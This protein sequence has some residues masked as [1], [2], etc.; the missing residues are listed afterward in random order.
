MTLA[1]HLAEDLQGRLKVWIGFKQFETAKAAGE[2]DPTAFCKV[3]CRGMRVQGATLSDGDTRTT[4]RPRPAECVLSVK[5]FSKRSPQLTRPLCLSNGLSR[6]G[7]AHEQNFFTILFVGSF[8]AVYWSMLECTSRRLE[9]IFDCSDMAENVLRPSATITA[10]R[11][12]HIRASL[13]ATSRRSLAS[14]CHGVMVG[15][16]AAWNMVSFSLKNP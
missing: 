10:T 15:F 1:W 16:A 8:F 4:C 5:R 9:H 13:L 3:F 14:R 2:G 12:A 7:S 6:S 11:I